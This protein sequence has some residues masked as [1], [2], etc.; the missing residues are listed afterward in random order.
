[1]T[2]SELS[3]NYWRYYLLLEKRFLETEE[4]VEINKRNYKTFSNGFSMLIQAIGAELDN[5]FKVYC[6]YNLQERKTITDYAGCILNDYPLITTQKVSVIDRDID[7][8]PFEK[9]DNMQ[10]AKS[11]TWWQVYDDIKHNRHGNIEKANQENTLSMLAALYLLEMKC[12]MR[13][14]DIGP[15][16]KPTEPD[17]PTEESKI[18]VIDD[19]NN[20]YTPLG[21]T[22]AIIDGCYYEIYQKELDD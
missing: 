18:F 16:G 14:V 7:L 8:V 15:D 12:F 13:F 4:Y 19:W 11:L 17:I 21:K 20:R 3:K 5:F 9:W 2:N 10:P 22:F 6:G 1:M